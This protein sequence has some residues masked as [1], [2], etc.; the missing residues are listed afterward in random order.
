MPFFHFVYYF[1]FFHIVKW[2][3][4]M[5]IV[6]YDSGFGLIPFYQILLQHKIY[7]TYFLEMEEEMFPLGEKSEKELIKYADKKIEEWKEKRIDHVFIVCN[8]FSLILKKMNLTSLP[9][10]L[11]LIIEE[12]LAL[13]KNKDA[14]IIGTK[15]TVTYLKKEGHTVINASKLVRFIEER[16]VEEIIKWIKKQK[17]KT[18]YLLLGC[19]H[20]SHIAFLFSIYFPHLILLDPYLSFLSYVPKGNHLKVYMNRK[21]KK[22]IKSFQN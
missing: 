20:F 11:H 15:R 6:I 7:H 21:A 8:T 5:R 2:V 10:Q 4:V 12:T 17:I 16:N 19:T 9:F 18:P 1:S 13:L 3:N 22:A 14:T